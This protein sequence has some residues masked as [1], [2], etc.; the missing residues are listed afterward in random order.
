MLDGLL[1]GYRIRRLSADA[2]V[3]SESNGRRIGISVYSD[4]TFG[5][6]L[7]IEDRTLCEWAEPAGEVISIDD[8]VRIISRMEKRLGKTVALMST[9]KNTA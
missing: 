7:W 5:A 2:Y 6:K 4:S 9:R 1:A 8:R 3:Y